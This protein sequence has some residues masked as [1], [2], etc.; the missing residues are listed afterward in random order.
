MISGKGVKCGKQYG[1]A[2]FGVEM[3][4]QID[5]KGQSAGRDLHDDKIAHELHQKR[6]RYKGC[7]PVEGAGQIVYEQSQK[8]GAKA[9][10]PGI[11][12]VL[13][14][15]QLVHQLGEEGHVL[16]V[17]IGVQKAFV[18]ERINAPCGKDDKQGKKGD[19]KG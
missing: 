19:E 10:I 18:S 17:H 16:V 8:I 1:H 15:F 4:A 13:S 3:S 14:V 5:S 6:L 11:V 9:D 2:A 7:K 12:Q